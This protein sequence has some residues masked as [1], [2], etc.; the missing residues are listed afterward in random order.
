M[1]KS[2]VS[3]KEVLVEVEEEKPIELEATDKRNT[4]ILIV[5]FLSA[6]TFMFLVLYNFPALTQDEKVK[7][8]RFPRGADDL[9]LINSV[10]QRYVTDHYYHVLLAFCSLYILL[11]TFA[12][13]G[14][15]FLSILSG[16]LFGGV[17]GF[18]LVG[19]CATTGACL[20]Y[21][22]SLVLGKGLVQKCFSKRLVQFQ[23]QLDKNR[24]DLIYYLL[25]L[26]VTPLLPNWFINISSPILNVPLSKFA[27]ATFI[28]LM[29]MNVVHVKTGLMLNDLQQVGG[30]DLK[31]VA[32]LFGIGFLALLPTFF[33]KRL[34]QKFE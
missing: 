17:Q 28:G 3:K 16:A 18:I 29:P 34:E 25:F 4:R 14:P 11:Q 6:C 32:F 24:D 30:I 31:T 15:I 23:T 20:C 9:R 7:L 21:T 26:R 8:F 10:I 2:N 27:L 13:P 22:M 12:I 5:L 19:L 33:K 1:S